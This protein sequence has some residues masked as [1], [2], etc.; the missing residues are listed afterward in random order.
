VG[1]GAVVIF[2]LSGTEGGVTSVGVSDG[3]GSTLVVWV[4][5]P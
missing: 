5:D 3:V 2:E 1:G 4:S